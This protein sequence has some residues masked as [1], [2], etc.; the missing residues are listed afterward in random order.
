M[1]STLGTAPSAPAPEPPKFTRSKTTLGVKG[2]APSNKIRPGTSVIVRR[3]MQAQQETEDVSASV[4]VLTTKSKPKPDVDGWQTVRSRCRRGSTHNLN[5]STRFHK[6]ST[7]TSMPALCVDS[8]KKKETNGDGKQKRRSVGG[9]VDKNVTNEVVKVNTDLRVERTNG[10]VGKLVNGELKVIKFFSPLK[11]IFEAFG[12][13]LNELLQS[14]SAPTSMTATNSTSQTI[15]AIFKSEAELL[16]KRIQQF[17]A[18]Q[19]ERERIILEE[20]RKTEEA[21]SQRSKQ[22][23]DEEASLQRQI[24]ELG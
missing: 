11:L 17:M 12:V 7:A 24:L 9:K 16:E 15:A 14:D 1:K 22:L 5:M 13:I 21:D 2:S 3:R 18:A 8:S 23:S 4:E 10:E 20:E 6:P 19:A